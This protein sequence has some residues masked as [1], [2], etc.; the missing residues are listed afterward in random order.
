MP[1]AMETVIVERSMLDKVTANARTPF[2]QA[3]AATLWNQMRHLLGTRENDFNTRTIISVDVVSRV[4]RSLERRELMSENYLRRLFTFGERALDVLADTLGTR[5]AAIVP[6]SRGQL[7]RREARRIHFT[8]HARN[9]GGP[10]VKS[11]SE[12][13]KMQLRR[14]TINGLPVELDQME[15]DDRKCVQVALNLS[16]FCHGVATY[17][18]TPRGLNINL[19]EIAAPAAGY[20]DGTDAVGR[21]DS[22]KSKAKAA[23]GE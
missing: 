1:E 10:E 11:T 9:Q 15:V 6:A 16:D 12:K 18:T 14:V 4:I 21:K 7:A 8:V 2:Q 20:A 22:K 3:L 13:E 17:G 5:F 23:A 19:P